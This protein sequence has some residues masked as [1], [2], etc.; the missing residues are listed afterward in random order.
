MGPVSV[1]L[2]DDSPL[3]LD[4]ATRFLQEE[5]RGEVVVVGVAGGGEEALAQAQ[6]LQPQ[7][8][9][10]DLNMPGM[11]GLEAIPRLREALPE[12]GIIALTLLDGEAYRQAALAAGADGFVSKP[13]M[14][15]DLLP[16]IR[17]VVRAD[18]F[19]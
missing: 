12:A 10:I 18:R 3:F 13:N 6:L 15:A 2:V 16:A 5:Y 9:L 11:S 1:L 14:G 7:V 19:I 4:I 17:R 8:I